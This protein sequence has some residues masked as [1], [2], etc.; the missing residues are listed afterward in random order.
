MLE[1][2]TVDVGWPQRA[3]RIVAGVAVGLAGLAG[4][5]VATGGLAWF[6][7]GARHGQTCSLG[8]QPWCTRGFGMPQYLATAGLLV[9]G[10]VVAGFA[11]SAPHRRAALWLAAAFCVLAGLAVTLEPFAGLPRWWFIA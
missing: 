6:W 8:M 10:V 7:A 1:G 9:S 11:V 4:A 2:E 5:V 3:V